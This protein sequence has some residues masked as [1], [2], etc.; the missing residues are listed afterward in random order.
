MSSRTKVLAWL[1]VPVAVIL[2]V[3]IL[4]PLL[5]A[6]RI[7]ARA[8]AEIERVVDAQVDWRDAGLTLF[9]DFPHLSL[10]LDDLTVVGV[11]RFEGDT[12]ASVP[13][14]R[15]VLDIGSMLFGDQTVIRSV[16]VNAPALRLI[17]LEDGEANWDIVRDADADATTAGSEDASFNIGLRGLTIRDGSIVFDNRRAGLIAS[18]DKLD[19]SLRGDFTRDRFVITTQT[20]SAA[21][22]VRSAGISYLD[23]VALDV[24]ADIDADMV[25]RTFIFGDN[26]VRL[27]DLLLT[28]TGN[29]TV[30]S[31]G[32]DLD[33][34]F[35]SPQNDFRSLLSLVPAIYARDFESLE[36][37]GDVSVTGRVAGR[38]G[39]QTFPAFALHARVDNASFRYPDLPLPARDIFLD[40]AIDNPGGHADSTVLNLRR[41]H[42]RVGEDAIAATMTV[43]TP[44]S[45][46]SVDLSLDGTIDLA[47]AARTFR[48]EGVEEL[49]G[50]VTA[51]VAV[52]ARKS[53]VMARQFDR[54]AASGNVVASN[55]V[56]H[57]TTLPHRI[58]IDDFALGISPGAADLR[59]L[60]GTIGSSDVR[61]QGTLDNLLGFAMGES[62]L[63]GSATLDSD[64]FDLTEWQSDDSLAVIL[65]PPHVDLTLRTAIAQLHHGRLDMTDARGVV[66]VKD[67]RLTIDSLRLN[68]VGGELRVAGH[69]ETTD[70][71]RPAFDIDVGITNADLAESFEALTTVR[72]LAPVARYAEG[73]F[74]TSLHLTGALGDDMTPILSAL[75]GRGALETSQLVLRDFPPMARLADALNSQRLQNP[76]LN[77]IRTAIDIRDG[78]LHVL[79]FDV[80]I[81]TSTLTVGGSN[82]IDRSL[83][84]DMVLALPQSSL[85]SGARQAVNDLF[86]RA[87]TA[88]GIDTLSMVRIGIQL[89]GTIDDPAISLDVGRGVETAVQSLEQAAQESADRAQQEIEERADS[90]RAE[91]RRRAEA[92]AQRLID[93]A[94]QRA[95]TIRAEARRLAE[96]IRA[97]A[98]ERADSLVAR[99]TSPIARVAAERVA[100]Q[101]RREADDR[102]NQ[103]IAEADSR[104]D[105][106]VAQARIQADALIRSGGAAA[107]TAD[108]R[109]PFPRYP[110]LPRL[111]RPA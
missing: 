29:A 55:V 86:A 87:G 10:S 48:L 4:V 8:K 90:A 13:G 98:N 18:L 6:D 24:V 97:E 20:Q 51:D 75:T 7:A 54:V 35:A 82:G 62:E 83:N 12:L 59:S 74:S 37:A 106:I 26:A 53:D 58:S 111:E 50:Q 109:A 108:D 3:L 92:E 102:A 96:G 40:L 21:V 38:Y 49:A 61:V 101:L 32:V 105:A 52:R 9:R 93:E 46:P 94:E 81:G 99:A 22:T 63:R 36:T 1:G 77:A 60:R 95:A 31:D 72:M 67:R 2:L 17:M 19:H 43:R 84:Y 33:I 5:F 80:G 85:E 110:P 68:A 44:M 56:L 47:S 78:R 23:R 103:I 25:T 73:S 34:E 89:T 41:F 16:D 28:F 30:G 69:Y 42:A 71:A 27:N 64:R 14:F 79:P 107:D 100:D 57:T 66:R 104:A 39:E 70:P 88:I 15:L 76:M 11:G 91:A 45:D 65:V